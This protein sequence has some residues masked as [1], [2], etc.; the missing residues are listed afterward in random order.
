V[1]Q[2]NVAFW[3]LHALAQGLMPLIGDSQAALA[4]LD[5]YKTAFPDAAMARTRAKLGLTTRD[6]G[7]HRLIEDLFARMAQDATDYTIAFRRLSTFDTTPGARND[8]VRDLF[9]DREAFDAWAARY[10]DRLAAEN[11]V[12]AERALR[13]N[14]V[15]PKY[16][17]RNHLAE[18][19]IRDARNGDFAEV[20]RL[21][22]ILARPF[23]EQPDRSAYADFPPDWAQQ[24]E[25]SCSS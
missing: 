7:D 1:R 11:S 17:L 20:E 14:R 22:E 6:E 12:D 13:M 15:N 21:R 19:A 24:I 23:D 25:V 4:A 18:V 8:V 16:I 10:R 3:N 5:V 9:V 2:P